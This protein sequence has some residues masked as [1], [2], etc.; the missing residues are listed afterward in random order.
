MCVRRIDQDAA[1]PINTLESVRY[2]DPMGSEN[3]D[4]ALGSLLFRPGDCARTEIGDKISQC[5]W[6]SR[7]GYNYGMTSGYQMAAERTRYV[8]GTYKPYFS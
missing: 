6:T 2:T 8:T 1:S 4:V 7:I 5:L 3:D